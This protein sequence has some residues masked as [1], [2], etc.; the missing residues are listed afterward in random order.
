M[1]LFNSSQPLQRERKVR[2]SYDLVAFILVAIGVG[3]AGAF[4]VSSA[5]L[6]IRTALAWLFALN[7]D[8]AMVPDSRRRDDGL[9]V[10]VALHRLGLDNP[11]QV[12]WRGA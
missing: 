12:V 4:L 11:Q 3:V 9:F 8:Q 6:P 7:S 10:A 2:I 5:G 1:N